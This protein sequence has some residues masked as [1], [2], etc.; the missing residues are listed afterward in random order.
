MFIIG[1]DEMK[2][3]VESLSIVPATEEEEGIKKMGLG[4]S[5]QPWFELIL[6]F[7]ASLFARAR[8]TAQMNRH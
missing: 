7:I 5:H 8:R 3:A 2:P 6:A 1:G 4:I